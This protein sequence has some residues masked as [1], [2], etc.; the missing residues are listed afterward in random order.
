M[1]TR[2]RSPAS[3]RSCPRRGSCRPQNAT[4]SM[5]ALRPGLTERRRRRVPHVLRQI[6][7]TDEEHI[8][9]FDREQL[10]EVARWPPAFRSCRP[11]A[12]SRDR[13]DRRSE[14]RRRSR[15]PGPRY[16]PSAP[17]YR[18]RRHSDSGSAARRSCECGRTIAAPPAPRMTCAVIRTSSKLQVPCSQSTKMLSAP[19]STSRTERPGDTWC[20]LNMVIAVALRQPLAQLRSVHG[21]FLPVYFFGLSGVSAGAPTQRAVSISAEVSRMKVGQI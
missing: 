6:A 8:D 2:R 16:R 18:R 5:T 21:A 7:G 11:P 9:A 4:F 17:S 12:A 1:A 13:P 10:V 3:R 19:S 20:G 15:A 14:P